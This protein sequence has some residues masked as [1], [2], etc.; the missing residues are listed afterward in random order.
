MRDAVVIVVLAYFYCTAII[1][2]IGVF[3]RTLVM[4]NNNNQ[5]T[6]KTTYGMWEMCT[7]P[8]SNPNNG[9]C[10][11]FDWQNRVLDSVAAD[12][13]RTILAFGTMTF[14]GAVLILTSPCFLPVL[15]YYRV[16]TNV[17]ACLF[18]G[19]VIFT[20]VMGSVTWSVLGAYFKDVMVDD[21]LFVTYGWGGTVFRVGVGMTSPILP[22]TLVY[23]FTGK[24]AINAVK[25]EPEKVVVP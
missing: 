10:V 18:L 15:F 21:V 13:V 5:E 12:R 7:A 6:H 16:K 9:F 14:I 17:M 4:Y 3:S 25:P 20:G 23:M 11:L 2:V 24:N 19:T 22:V 8:F 1:I